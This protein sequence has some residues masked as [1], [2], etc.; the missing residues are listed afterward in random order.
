MSEIAALYDL[1]DAAFE[2]A[3][4]RHRALLADLLDAVAAHAP[5]LRKAG[6]TSID[7]EAFAATLAPAEEVAPPR[8]PDVGPAHE[9]T[10]DPLFDPMTYGS[11]EVPGSARPRGKV[12]R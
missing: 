12:D 4:A 10:S 9:D 7:V 1:E 11:A 3:R 5:A 8:L 6:I 2:R